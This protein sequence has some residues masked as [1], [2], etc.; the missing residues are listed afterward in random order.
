MCVCLPHKPW[1]PFSMCVGCSHILIFYSGG[2]KYYFFKN[3][4]IIRWSKRFFSDFFLNINYNKR[5]IYVCWVERQEKPFLYN[6][7][8]S[9]PTC[10]LDG[11][12][13]FFFSLVMSSCYDDEAM[14]PGFYYV[15]LVAV[16]FLFLPFSFVPR[17]TS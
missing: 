12:V 17:K 10:L 1:K 6:I 16:F 7:S 2:P 3:I 15:L 9:L 11:W 13:V 4:H 5:D 8:I 14:L